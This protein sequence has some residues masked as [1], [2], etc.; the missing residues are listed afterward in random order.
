MST[1]LNHR[2]CVPCPRTQKA[3][4]TLGSHDHLQEDLTSSRHHYTNCIKAAAHTAEY[5]R[6]S[7]T[8]TVSAR[9][10]PRAVVPNY[11]RPTQCLQACRLAS[12]SCAPTACLC[13]HHLICMR[14]THVCMRMCLRS[15]MCGTSVRMPVSRVALGAACDLVGPAS[16]GRDVRRWISRL[17]F[18]R[19]CRCKTHCPHAS[20]AQPARTGTHLNISFVVC[21]NLLD[22]ASPATVWIGSLW[23]E[24]ATRDTS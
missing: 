5:A 13:K 11:T 17:P 21:A 7:S 23:H 6:R 4:F 20:H 12:Y 9:L 14:C 16:P 10:S 2:V 15:H 24:V 1:D 3:A 19:G 22:R 8:R 18:P